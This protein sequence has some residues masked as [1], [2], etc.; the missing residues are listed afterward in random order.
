[1]AI[2][3]GKKLTI[4]IYGESHADKVGAVVHGFP[5]LDYDSEELSRFMARR[6]A[7]GAVFSTARIE[8]DEPVWQGVTNGHVEG[9]FAVDIYNRN[10][11]SNDYDALQAKPRPAHA[12]YAWHLKDGTTNFAGGGRFSARLTA[13]LVAV[14]GLCKQYLHQKGVDVYAYIA[15]IGTAQGMSYKNADFRWQAAVEASALPFPAAQ[16]ASE[17][18]EQ[19]AAAKAEG[20]SVGGR[21]ECLVSGLAGGVGDNLF[22]GLEGKLAALL[23]AI[24][25][26]KGVE[27]GSGFDLCRMRGSEANDALFYDDGKVCFATNHM[28]GINGGISNGNYLSM[29]VAV[30]PT[31]SIAKE[32]R[33]VDLA[34]RQNTTIRIKGRHDA[35]IVPRAVPV[36]EAAV[37][38]ALTDESAALE[39]CNYNKGD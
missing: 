25:A 2:F 32:Q 37:A 5:P 1:M 24:P 4:E 12:D 21:I 9:D 16:N 29:A 33:T 17:M 10:V 20:D 28:G 23:Y 30:K 3:R 8:P 36:V 22:E 38:I 6:R 13:P 26:V 14:G 11:H 34:L 27:F 31:P 18:L 39:S 7:S 15:A 35:C 19:I